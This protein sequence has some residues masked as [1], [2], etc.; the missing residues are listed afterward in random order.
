M[1]ADIQAFV[2]AMAEQGVSCDPIENMSWVQLTRV[3]L[4]GSGKLGYLSAP[5]HRAESGLDMQFSEDA[6]C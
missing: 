2:A 1:C 5:P 6:R 4:L 3:K